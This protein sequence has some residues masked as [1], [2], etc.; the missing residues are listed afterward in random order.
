MH[1]CIISKLN[2]T[3]VPQIRK[4]YNFLKTVKPIEI[5]FDFAKREGETDG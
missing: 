1:Y 2:V 5:G 4:G 3:F